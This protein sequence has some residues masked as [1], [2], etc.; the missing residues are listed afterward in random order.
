MKPGMFGCCQCNASCCKKRRYAIKVGASGKCSFKPTN[1][2][3]N[4]NIQPLVAIMIFWE[5]LSRL[6]L[7]FQILQLKARMAEEASRMLEQE[8]MQLCVLG[9][10]LAEDADFLDTCRGFKVFLPIFYLEPIWG[11]QFWKM[12][13]AF[14]GVCNY[15]WLAGASADQRG[16][17]GI[18][19]ERRGRGLHYLCPSA[20][21]RW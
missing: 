9:K 13:N 11:G 3:T 14:A 1:V 4:Q 21:L 8:T 12:S 6:F 15:S 2:C 17:D 20:F 18:D 10:T 5:I 19:W 7:L 16:W